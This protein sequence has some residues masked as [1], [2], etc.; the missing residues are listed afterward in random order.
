MGD[1]YFFVDAEQFYENY[2]ASKDK[3][4]VVFAGLVHGITPMD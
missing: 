1:H 3:D 2:S 4:N